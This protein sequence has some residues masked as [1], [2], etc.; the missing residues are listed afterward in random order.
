MLQG[1]RTCDDQVGTWTV[2]GGRPPNRPRSA[3]GRWECEPGYWAGSGG[4]SP[5]PSEYGL[6]ELRLYTSAFMVWLAFVLAWFAG[7]VLRER[8]ERFMTGALAG[9]AVG[10]LALAV[11]DPD[12]TIVRMNGARL[13]PAMAAPEESVGAGFD[14]RYAATLGP[15]AAP[16]LLALWPRLDPWRRCVV[17][18]ALL[19]DHPRRSPDWRTWSWGRDR[20]REVVAR[21][22]SALAAAFRSC[23]VVLRAPPSARVGDP[24]RIE[25]TGFTADDDHVSI[26]QVRGS[27][28]QTFAV[29]ATSNR[30]LTLGVPHVPGTYEIRYELGGS[31][32]IVARTP[33]VVRPAAQI[34][35]ANSSTAV[36]QSAGSPT[37]ISPSSRTTP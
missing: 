26:A 33:L 37:R 7:T 15:D 24:V 12:A 14:S 5:E 28:D 30:P 31:R 35:T 20:S 18:E 8:R 19:A 9:V 1:P 21:K 22:R 17:A 13:P 25:W 27:Y 16:A 36:T 6:T 10:I 3:T 29:S 11:L 2:P 4:A 34:S 23:P 32:R